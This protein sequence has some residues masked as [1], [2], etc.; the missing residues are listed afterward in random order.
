M[1]EREAPSIHKHERC[2]ALGS[3]PGILNLNSH[4]IIALNIWYLMMTNNQCLSPY[5][6]RRTENFC[7]FW[8]PRRFFLHDD[9][10]SNLIMR[11]HIAKHEIFFRLWIQW[12]DRF[13]RH[14]QCLPMEDVCEQVRMSFPNWKVYNYN[15]AT[16]SSL[17]QVFRG[18]PS[19][20]VLNMILMRRKK[21]HSKW[22]RWAA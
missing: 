14:D 12:H 16:Y 11:A 3:M 21:K 1:S 20:W 5:Q 6:T 18:T 9:L 17:N 13:R 22:L 10:M 19:R 2:W 8:V 7:P 15:L 4:R